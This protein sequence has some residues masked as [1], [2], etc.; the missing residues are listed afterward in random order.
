MWINIILIVIG[1]LGLILALMPDKVKEKIWAKIIRFSSAIRFMG[2]ILMLFA[3]IFLII[4]KSDEISG[5]LKIKFPITA[6]M[7][8]LQIWQITL[9]SVGILY[10]S[11]TVFFGGLILG[12]YFEKRLLQQS[13]VKSEEV[14][15]EAV[16]KFISCSQDFTNLL[17]ADRGDQGELYSSYSEFQKSTSFLNTKLKGSH[18]KRAREIINSFNFPNMIEDTLINGIPLWGTSF[19]K[20]IIDLRKNLAKDINSK[21]KEIQ[22][23]LSE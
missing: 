15:D 12:R 6:Q 4:R 20:K 16:K 14:T 23:V 3:S 17:L 8:E 5:F 10:M 21:V 9:G 19:P 7:V 1:F 22:D 2:V 11:L 13:N 18:F